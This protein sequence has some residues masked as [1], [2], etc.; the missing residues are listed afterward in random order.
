MGRD[1]EKTRALSRYTAFSGNEWTSTLAPWILKGSESTAL[2]VLESGSSTPLLWAVAETIVFAMP[3]FNKKG[4]GISP[5]PLQGR[6]SSGLST[7]AGP[8]FLRVA[9]QDARMR[10]VG[11]FAEQQQVVPAKA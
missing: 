9:A 1:P 3:M 5:R 11:H 4:A 10:L 6:V 8:C 7:R 2:V